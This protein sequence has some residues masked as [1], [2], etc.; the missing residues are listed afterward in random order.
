MSD[1][2]IVDL[3]ARRAAKVEEQD[4]PHLHGEAF[5]TACGSTWIAVA[6]TGTVH[7]DCPVCQRMQGLFKHGVEPEVAWVCRC[8]ERLFWLTKSGAMCRR[9]GLMASGWVDG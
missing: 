2:K 9:C 5:C 6:P 8:D 3:A 4:G 1:D 7:L